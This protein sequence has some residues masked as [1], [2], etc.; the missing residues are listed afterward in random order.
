MEE[1][2]GISKFSWQDQEQ[3]ITLRILTRVVSCVFVLGSDTHLELQQNRY[4]VLK[5][6]ILGIK[7]VC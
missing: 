6:G 3:K 4:I 1:P 5:G 7:G 2:I